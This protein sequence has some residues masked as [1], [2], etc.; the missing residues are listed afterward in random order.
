MYTYRNQRELQG[1]WLWQMWLQTKRP[2]EQQTF[3]HKSDADDIPRQRHTWLGMTQLSALIHGLSILVRWNRINSQFVIT[4]IMT[5]SFV[6]F[7]LSTMKV[8][9]NLE[10]WRLFDSTTLRKDDC[11]DN[12]KF[13]D[14][15]VSI[16]KHTRIPPC[17]TRQLQ[18]NG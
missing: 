10:R 14:R 9:C 12:S 3:P 1:G 2:R 11:N 5:K 8:T 15:R 4:T 17:H 13:L 6:A 16:L 18:K 7:D